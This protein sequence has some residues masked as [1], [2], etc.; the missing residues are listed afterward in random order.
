MT[1]N[2]TT[3]AD[4]TRKELVEVVKF[5]SQMVGSTLGPRGQNV[6]I[7]M[8]D[9]PATITKDGV[10]V[11]KHTEMN[12]HAKNA[13]L[14]IIKQAAYKT[15]EECGDGTTTSIVL[16]AAIVEQAQ[17]LLAAGHNYTDLREGMAKAV[18]ETV[19]E[20]SASASNITSKDD[21]KHVATISANGDETIGEL[22]ATAIDLMGKDGAIVV[23][24]SKTEQTKLDLTEGFRFDGGFI[25]AEFINVESERMVRYDD[26]YI[27]VTTE[28]ISRVAEMIP[29]LQ[30]AVKEK[31]A[32][33]VIAEDV[34]DEALASL[35]M[36]V[37]KGTLKVSAIKAPRY[38]TER[39][40][41]LEDLAIATGAKLVSPGTG[42]D[43]ANVKLTDLGR[44]KKIEIVRGWT[45]IIDGGGTSEQVEKRINALKKD[46]DNLDDLDECARI[47]E[48][49]T[50]LSS[51]V[52][53]I[54]IGGHTEAEV[55]EKRF[56]VDDALGAVRAAQE[57]GILPGG[58]TFLLRVSNFLK[59]GLV[60]DGSSFMFG[61]QIIIDA[62]KAPF[63]RI[64]SN[65]GTNA[66]L[67]EADLDMN[68]DGDPEG[69]DFSKPTPE[70]CDL[71][72][73]G[74]IDPAK[75][76]RCALQNAFSVAD[77][78]LTTGN[79]IVVS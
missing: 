72:E 79:I 16:A 9:K 43:L 4:D 74:V 22:I 61:K 1:H 17:K 33:V 77:L 63:S 2:Y 64:A 30:W 59:T 31:Q 23:K 20:I 48:R 69:W 65:A 35:V 56:R 62:L 12:D 44:A 34:V 46:M 36:N 28:K 6:L 49:I 58:G 14:E 15:N 32:L 29:T 19:W 38:G 40:N 60:K 55:I 71:M 73:R 75:V 78:L 57:E 18:E 27:L 66:G 68:H 41:I 54:S 26:P 3:G 5:L 53:V 50:R 47:Q 67:Y 52:A 8:A 25:S 24:E 13:I 37:T 7:N 10:T 39:Q 11:A 45:T 70:K 42:L 21:I 51:G 76:T